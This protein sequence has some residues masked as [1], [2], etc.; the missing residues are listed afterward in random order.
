MRTTIALDEDV[1]ARLKAYMRESGLGMKPALNE[2][3]RL[4]FEARSQR[5]ARSSYK[6]PT[7]DLGETAAGLD[8]DRIGEA[9]ERLEGP[10]F[11]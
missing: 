6:A 10:G 2:V 4:G 9:L 8:L 5:K 1:A 3:M 11:R 7:F